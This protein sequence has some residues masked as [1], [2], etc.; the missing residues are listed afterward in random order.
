MRGG[1]WFGTG[2]SKCISG[3][4]QS[5]GDERQHP[6]HPVPAGSLCYMGM[7]APP[8][9]HQGHPR[10]H[11]EVPREATIPLQA[12][13]PC[14][15]GLGGKE[16]APSAVSGVT[17]SEPHYAAAGREAASPGERATTTKFWFREARGCS[18]SLPHTPHLGSK[19]GTLLVWGQAALQGRGTATK[20][21]LF[22][23][24]TCRFAPALL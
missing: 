22:L 1:G 20:A 23:L 6:A 10:H 18:A 11:T 5:T 17:P 2:W 9:A 13:L 14:P 3:R 24:P 16:L 15:G 4:G 12:A 21:S 8:P 7:P 19:P